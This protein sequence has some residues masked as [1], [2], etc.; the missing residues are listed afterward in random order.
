MLHFLNQVLQMRILDRQ[1]RELMMRQEAHRNGHTYA[2]HRRNTEPATT[3][4]DVQPTQAEE[5]TIAPVQTELQQ[6]AQQAT[7]RQQEAQE[8]HRNFITQGAS[9]IFNRLMLGRTPSTDTPDSPE[10]IP[11]EEMMTA[12]EPPLS[13]KE[14]LI[15]SR[16]DERHPDIQP[17]FKQQAFEILNSVKDRQPRIFANNL[18]EMNKVVTIYE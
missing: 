10:L 17:E 2:L 15:I 4:D 8:Q 6:R 7:Q 12:R 9:S 14:K 18:T 3:T 5:P 11:D 16:I 13:E 1:M